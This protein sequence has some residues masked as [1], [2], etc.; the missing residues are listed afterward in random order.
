V[1]DG[2]GGVT[3]RRAGRGGRLAPVTA[4]V[5]AGIVAVTL[6]LVVVTEALHRDTERRLQDRLVQETGAVLTT[7]I[8]GV[9]TPLGSAAEVA[10]QTGGDPA[11]FEASLQAALQAKVVVGAE[12]FDAATGRRL[13]AVGTPTSLGSTAPDRIAAMVAQAQRTP[14]LA[15]VDTLDLPGR[16]LGYAV[17]PPARP[18]GYVVYAEAQLPPR[19]GVPRASGPFSDLEYALYLGEREDDGE[20]LYSSLSR[21]PMTGQRA[22]TVVPFGDRSLLLV[23]RSDVALSGWTSRALPVFVAVVGL[24]VALAAGVLTERLVRRRREA[25]RLAGDVQALYEDQRRRTITLQRSLLPERLPDTPGLEL[26]VR[27]WPAEVDADVGGDFYDA[28]ALADGRYAIVIGD[29]CG[30]G[31]DAAALT[32]LAR[33]TVRAGV[34]HATDPVEVLRWTH[35]AVASSGRSTFCTV[36]LALLERRGDVG[37]GL[38]VTLGG[39]PAPLWCRADGTVTPVGRAGTLLGLVEP[40]LHTTHVELAHGDTV[41][42]YTDGITDAPGTAAIDEAQLAEVLAAHAGEPLDDVAVA[43]RGL[44]DSRR[45]DGSDDDIALVLLRVGERVRPP[46]SVGSARGDEVAG[47]VAGTGRARQQVAGEGVAP[48]GDE[49][50]VLVD[51]LDALGH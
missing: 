13:A 34:R 26:A 28:F 23:G 42:L 14:S 20:L 39:H 22:R 41:L 5:V 18:A 47:G 48:E 44:L 40:R 6:V 36:C 24:A 46:A 45:P 9:R 32:G 27:Y 3:G 50:G 31:I 33:H 25:E 1:G 4:L 21:T 30:S 10:A 49:G 12:L 37:F 43:V 38:D 17:A 51:R 8:S 2:E 7:A 19:L 15:V 35:E 11:A 16:R 29:V